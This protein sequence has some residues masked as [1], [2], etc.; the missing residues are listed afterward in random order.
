MVTNDG[1]LKFAESCILTPSLLARRLRLDDST[2]EQIQFGHQNDRYE[3]IYQML[4]KWK[5]SQPS[6]TWKDLEE[7]TDSGVKRVLN[8]IYQKKDRMKGNSNHHEDEKEGDEYGPPP[9]KVS[10]EDSPLPSAPSFDLVYPVQ[11]V[12]HGDNVE[13]TKCNTTDHSCENEKNVN[14]TEELNHD[15]H[16][17]K[18]R[19]LTCKYVTV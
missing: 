8:D 7:A 17:D 14:S 16:D 18:D 1:L 10:K 3:Q 6:G 2:I 11:E 5:Q 12:G 4:M 9:S 13:Y 19:A 15:V